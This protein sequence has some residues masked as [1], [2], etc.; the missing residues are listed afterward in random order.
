MEKIQNQKP[1]L[2]LNKQV[3]AVLA[4]TDMMNIKGGRDG[5]NNRSWIGCTGRPT[6]IPD[7]S[8]I[9]CGEQESN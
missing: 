4:Q 7:M 2:K 5:M 3:I 1:K 8:F 9:C 6:S